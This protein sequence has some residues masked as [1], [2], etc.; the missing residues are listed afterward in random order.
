M[1]DNNKPLFSINNVDRYKAA[2]DLI[3]ES[4]GNAIYYSLLVLSSVIISAGLLL[5]NSAILIGGMLVTPVLNPV[6]LLA[7]GITASLPKVIKRTLV[8]ILKS[9][10][11]VFAIAFISGIIFNIPEGSGLQEHAL[12]DNT[13]RAAFLYFL[14]AFASGVAATFAWVRKEITNILPGISIAVSVVPPLAM[15]AIWLAELEFESMKFFLM[16]FLFNVFGIVSGSVVVFSVLRFYKTEKVISHKVDE[17][18]R[19]ENNVQ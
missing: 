9:F 12:F 3:K 6:L 17:Q 19:H 16:V 4:E 10:G 2:T 5:S 13:F 7:L 18:I 8:L 15:V 1:T 14:V 11:T